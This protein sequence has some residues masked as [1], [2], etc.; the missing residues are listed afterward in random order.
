MS[1]KLELFSIYI[2]DNEKIVMDVPDE[3]YENLSIEDINTLKEVTGILYDL[4]YKKIN[5]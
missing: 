1:K 5:K 4:L 2:E 3:L